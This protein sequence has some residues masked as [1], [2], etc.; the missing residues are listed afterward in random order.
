MGAR[1]LYEDDTIQH[2]GVVIGFGG[3]AG[4]TFIGLHEAE[5]SYFHRAMCAQDY[6]AVTAACLMVKKSVFEEVGGLTEE[7][8]VAFNDVDFC[9]KVRAGRL[10]GGLRAVRG[11]ASLRVQVPRTGGY[12][13]EGGTLQP[14]V[15][16]GGKALAGYFTERRSVLQPEPDTAQVRFSPCGIS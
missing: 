16:P 2:A 5:N 7:L 4:H 13:G 9:L 15:G 3:V 8:A 11:D 6:S 12:T 10:S 14:R 1:L